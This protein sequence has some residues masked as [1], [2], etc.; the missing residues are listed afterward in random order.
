MDMFFVIVLLVYFAV[1]IVTI[2]WVCNEA[3][4]RYGAS[5]SKAF[6]FSFFFSPIAGLLYLLLFP[7]I[8]DI[9]IEEKKVAPQPNE[10]T[11]SDKTEPERP[12]KRMGW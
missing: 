3:E 7:R 11:E 5:S 10:N 4:K 6:V 8:K 2:A 9:T 12:V 1:Y